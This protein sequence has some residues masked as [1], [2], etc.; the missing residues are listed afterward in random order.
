VPTILGHHDVK[1]HAH[2]LASPKREE[3]FGPLGVTDIRTFIDPKNPDHVALIMDVPDMDAFNAAMA[4]EDS[5]RG[6]GLRRRAT[7]DPGH[8]RRGLGQRRRP[9]ARSE[10]VTGPSRGRPLSLPP[11]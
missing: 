5:G 9:L 4:S 3:F 11:G 6:D 10:P 7:R 8:P 2:W 1:D